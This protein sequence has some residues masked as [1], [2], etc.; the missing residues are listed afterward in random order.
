MLRNVISLNLLISNR[1]ISYF[2][3]FLT[4][5]IWSIHDPWLSGYRDSNLIDL[6]ICW[7]RNS[8]NF[9]CMVRTCCV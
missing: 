9:F 5:S 8:I 6:L 2:I 4:I 3:C 7:V 1:H